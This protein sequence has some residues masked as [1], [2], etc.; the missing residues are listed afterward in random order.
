[1]KK[2]LILTGMM[3]AGKS[4]IGKDLSGKLNIQF[5]DIDKNGA[6]LLE[7]NDKK[8]KTVYAGD[9]FLL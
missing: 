9:V 7:V 2:S 1:M 8:I 4:T 6:L 3:G 5:K